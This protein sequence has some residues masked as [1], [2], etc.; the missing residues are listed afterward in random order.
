MTVRYLDVYH[1]QKHL[2]TYSVDLPEIRIGRDKNNQICLAG[3]SISRVHAIIH[4]DDEHVTFQDQ[5]RNGSYI[6]GTLVKQG[7]VP[8]S[9]SSIV[10]ISEYRIILNNRSLKMNWQRTEDLRRL[11]ADLQPLAVEIQIQNESRSTFSKIA[12]IDKISISLDSNSNLDFSSHNPEISLCLIEGM[13][14]LIVHTR[15]V[16]L[17]GVRLSK[18][19]YTVRDG[20]KIHYQNHKFIISTA[21]QNMEKLIGSSMIMTE[22]KKNITLI[23]E[24]FSEAPVLILGETGTGKDIVAELIHKHSKRRDKNFIPVNCTAIPQS[25]SESLLFGHKAGSFTDARQ[26]SNGFFLEANGGTLFLD[27]IGD[28]DPTIQTKLLRAIECQEIIPVGAHSPI[29]IDVRVICGTNKDI[30]N[31]EGRKKCGFRDD[32][33]YRISA[34]EMLIPS[35]RQRKEDIPELIR[36]FHE[37]LCQRD[38]NLKNIIITEKAINCALDYDWPGNVRELKQQTE[39]AVC[40]SSNK[41]YQ[42]PCHNPLGA[43]TAETKKFNNFKILLQMGIHIDMIADILGL[44]R[45]TIYRWIERSSDTHSSKN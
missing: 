32:L 18:G 42:I 7:V 30:Q 31:Q 1:G 13:I 16:I 33:Y 22:L 2:Y 25:L 43:V 34:F 28:L 5:S 27:E 9:E 45:S 8:F 29:K 26:D 36:H 41:V 4:F 15:H 37:Q 12:L 40:L 44:S 10:A 3:D 17:N 39:R 21:Q 20:D 14:H 11:S 19:L 23:N 38:P 6:D 35:L 24:R